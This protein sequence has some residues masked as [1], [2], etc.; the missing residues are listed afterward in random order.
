MNQD[1]WTRLSDDEKAKVR[2]GFGDPD[3]VIE[4]TQDPD[5]SKPGLGG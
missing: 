2:G 1:F 4:I 5:P 3:E